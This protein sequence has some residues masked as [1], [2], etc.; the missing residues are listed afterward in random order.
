MH[1]ILRQDFLL[2]LWH[3]LKCTTLFS[4]QNTSA[5]SHKLFV[6]FIQKLSNGTWLKKRKVSSLIGTHT[7]HIRFY[8]FILYIFKE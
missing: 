8:P 2:S 6:H 1:E 7:Q 5:F 4:L 3:W